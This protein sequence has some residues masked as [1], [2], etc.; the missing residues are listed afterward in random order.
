MEINDANRK[1]EFLPKYLYRGQFDRTDEL[2]NRILERNE[3]ENPLAP[4]FTPRPVLSKYSLFPMLDARKQP[5]VPIQPN[6]N[7]SIEKNFTPPVMKVGPVSGIINNIQLESELRNQIYAL[8]KGN[9]SVAYVPSSNS[10]LYKVY[11]PST[12]S[13]QPYPNLFKE[14]TFSQ[15]I[16]PNIQSNPEVGKDR[17]HNNTRTQLKNIVH[18]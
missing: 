4:N 3:P 13:N 2:N 11:I 6:Y 17:F 15:L 14:Q 9:D 18:K 10:D 1:T 7:Y 8:N 5:T 16:H 12:P